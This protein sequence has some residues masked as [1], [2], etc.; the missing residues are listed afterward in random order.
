MLDEME[1]VNNAQYRIQT[2]QKKK[3]IE[4]NADRKKRHV[5]M[6]SDQKQKMVIKNKADIHIKE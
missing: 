3:K 2:S 5:S 4:R 6:E 1:I